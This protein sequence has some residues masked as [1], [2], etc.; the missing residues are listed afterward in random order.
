M[1]VKKEEEGGI[2]LRDPWCAIDAAKI[3]IFVNLMTKDRQPWMS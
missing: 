1:L 2:G 3:R